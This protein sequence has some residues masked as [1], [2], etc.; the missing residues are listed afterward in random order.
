MVAADGDAAGRDAAEALAA[1]ARA[2]GWDVAIRAAPEGRDWN[3]VAR[4]RAT[5]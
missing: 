2:A 5:A 1:R 3:D 4:E